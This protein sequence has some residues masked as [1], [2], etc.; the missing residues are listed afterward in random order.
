ML[1]PIKVYWGSSHDKVHKLGNN[2]EISKI[3]I[4]I[5]LGSK[6]RFSGLDLFKIRIRIFT[7]HTYHDDYIICIV[8]VLK[9]FLFIY[10]ES[11]DVHEHLQCEF[12]N[13]LSYI[14]HTGDRIVDIIHT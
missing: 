13:G 5:F 14:A 3:L 7:Y 4:F 11:L 10:L 6:T 12:T 2:S 1:L 9:K 8:G